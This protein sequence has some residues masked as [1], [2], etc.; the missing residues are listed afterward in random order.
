MSRTDIEPS[1]SAI[2][3]LPANITSVQ[4]GGGVCYRMELTWG[5]WRRWYSARLS[6]RLSATDGR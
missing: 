6:L 5:K 3:P 1:T 4:P 2:E